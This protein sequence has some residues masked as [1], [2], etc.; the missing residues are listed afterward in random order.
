MT[1][2]PQRDPGHRDSWHLDPWRLE[3]IKRRLDALPQ[4]LGADRRVCLAGQ[5]PV[6]DIEGQFRLAGLRCLLT[7]LGARPAPAARATTIWLGHGVLP[8]VPRLLV[9]PAPG[10][11]A[12]APGAAA[13]PLPD[14]MHALWGLLAHHPPGTGLLHL[15]E[16]PDWRDMLPLLQRLPGRM[17]LLP[18][19][20]RALLARAQR[21][22][23]AHA[24]VAAPRV[25]GSI[26]AALLGRG[27]RPTPA[28]D[29]YWG[30]W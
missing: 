26:L 1:A 27:F 25:A 30:Q 7:A 19:L 29:A 18:R 17:P 11:P 16:V 12:R 15:P 8:V 9:W 2:L 13:L 6:E 22:V 4:W 28:T 21:L 24:E 10:A 14:P 3:R 20:R 5:P 23:R